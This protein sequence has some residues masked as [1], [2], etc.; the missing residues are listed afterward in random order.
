MEEQIKLGKVKR[1]GPPLIVPAVASAPLVAFNTLPQHYLWLE[2][3]RTGNFGRNL[4]P[5][6]SFD[7]PDGLIDAGWTD[8]SYRYD[9]VV[10]KVSTVPE[11]DPDDGRRMVKMEVKPA[12]GRAV[13]TLLP[14]LDQP[15]AS[16]RSPAVPV[17]AGQFLRITVFVR[18]PFYT[19][20]AGGLVVSDSLGGEALRFVSNEPIV[21][22][23]RLV[24]YRRA[25]ADGDLT[26]SLGLAGYGEAYFDNLSVE[27]IE[28]PAAVPPADVARSPRPR[29]AEAVPPAAARAGAAR[30]PAR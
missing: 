18:R 9:G 26:V 24:L 3:M 8:E 4:I 5:S 22:R 21:K 12:P 6:G 19:E 17:K 15:V 16:I 25:P 7:R 29:R 28:A 2:W 23:S 30:T 1:T 14:Y 27:R 10:A 20:G 13:D 11:A